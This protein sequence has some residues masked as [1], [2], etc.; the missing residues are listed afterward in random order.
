MEAA[1]TW[2]AMGSS[3]ITA[4]AMR[5]EAALIF[6]MVDDPSRVGGSL[7]HEPWQLTVVEKKVQESEQVTL[8]NL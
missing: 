4:R 6:L 1:L 8:W 2:L 7:S 5:Q 3:I